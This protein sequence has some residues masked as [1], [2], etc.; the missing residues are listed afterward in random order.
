MNE[1]PM[2]LKN[3]KKTLEDVKHLYN[4]EKDYLALD[5][6]RENFNKL[7]LVEGRV[8]RLIGVDKQE[9]IY[10]LLIFKFPIM[11]RKKGLKYEMFSVDD[12]LLPI[13]D[14]ELSFRQAVST[15]MS[16]NDGGLEKEIMYEYKEIVFEPTTRHY[17][18][19]KLKGIAAQEKNRVNVLEDYHL[20]ES[21]VDQSVNVAILVSA[22]ALSAFAIYIAGNHYLA[23]HIESGSAMNLMYLSGIILG[24]LLVGK[25]IYGIGKKLMDKVRR[26][27][28]NNALMEMNDEFLLLLSKIGVES[29]S[30]W[31]KRTTLKGYRDK[32]EQ[33]YKSILKQEYK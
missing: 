22:I 16:S 30:Q 3:K 25:F 17:Y 4:E 5:M 24:S 15:L 1:E 23:D 7:Y 8:G 32:I 20:S 29:A 26:R 9:G 12:Q 31:S 21:I 2:V 18:L 33:V 19:E 13:K 28:A 11:T 10:P 14:A 6:V 27:K